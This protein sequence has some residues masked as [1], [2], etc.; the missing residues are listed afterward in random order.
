M[1]QL[2]ECKVGTDNNR[3]AEHYSRFELS[4]CEIG[5]NEVNGDEVRDD[6]VEKKSQKMSKSKKLSKFKKMLRLDFS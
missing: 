1:I 2:E 6:E 5:D 4:K 3:K